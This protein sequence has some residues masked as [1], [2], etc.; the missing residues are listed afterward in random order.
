MRTG[1]ACNHDPPLTN[2]LQVWRLSPIRWVYTQGK[3]G[4][5]RLILALV[6]C[7]VVIP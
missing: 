1:D 5:E 2:T 6:L 7:Q 4:Q 3:G